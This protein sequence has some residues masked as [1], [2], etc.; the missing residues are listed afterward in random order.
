MASLVTI[1]RGQ[2]FS[3]SSSITCC[4]AFSANCRRLSSTAGIVPLAGSPIPM[5]SVKQFIVL[6]V[7]IPAQLPGPGQATSS[8]RFNSSSVICF[9]ATLP[10]ASNTEMRST[11]LVPSLLSRRPV[12]MGPPLMKIA[13]RFSLTAAISIPGTTLS[14]LGIKTKASKA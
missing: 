14:Q 4:P 11:C 3:A 2:I 9:R 1:S 6:A 8:S 12:S 10:T 13:G 7:N 5:A